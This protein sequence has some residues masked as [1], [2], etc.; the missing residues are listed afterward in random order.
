MIYGRWMGRLLD[1]MS[2]RKVLEKMWMSWCL[3]EQRKEPRN[4]RT[5]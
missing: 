1:G 3:T 5:V 2:L 4:H